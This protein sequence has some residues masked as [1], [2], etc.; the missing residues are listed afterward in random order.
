MSTFIWGTVSW[1]GMNI[2]ASRDRY[3]SA[4]TFGPPPRL[5]NWPKSPHRLGLTLWKGLSQC[6]EW[7]YLTTISQPFHSIYGLLIK[8]SNPGAWSK[9]FAFTRSNFILWKQQGIANTSGAWTKI[10]HI[11]IIWIKN[12]PL[13]HTYIQKWNKNPFE[14]LENMAAYG[15]QFSHPLG[16]C[17]NSS[18][19]EWQVKWQ[20]F[21]M[22]IIWNDTCSEWHIPYFHK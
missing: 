3:L 12:Q 9:W 18:Y 15:G 5:L 8:D 22:T 20:I 21:G 10:F 19:L 11:S 13:L 17:V 2:K 6:W 1:A 14:V 7:P 4:G 16:A